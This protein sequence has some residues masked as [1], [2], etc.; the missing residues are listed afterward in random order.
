MNDQEEREK[1]LKIL[2]LDI[3]NMGNLSLSDIMKGSFSYKEL[4]LD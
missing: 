1:E 3:N 4:K 2:K